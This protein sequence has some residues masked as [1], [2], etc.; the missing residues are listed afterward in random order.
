MQSTYHL[1]RLAN[2]TRLAS[3]EMPYMRSV[4]VGIWVGVGG[5]HE[6]EEQS[7]ISHFLEHLLFKGTK[8]RSAKKITES[9]EGLGG[10]LN[11]FTTEDH[12]CYYAK[13][14]APH[15][16]QLCDVLCDMYLE[17]VFAPAE[18]EREREVIREEILMYR[19]H[20][21]QHAQELLT[22]TMWPQHPL[23]RPLTGSVETISRFK[24]G[25][26]MKFQKQNYT[27]ATTIVTVAGPVYHERVVE[28]LKP[29]LSRLPRGRAPRYVRAQREKGPA[30]LS[31]Y[32]QETEQT[33]L[34]MGFHAFGRA[35]E[36]RFA[37][38]LLS[39]ILGEN[40]SSRLFQK[41]RERHGWCYNVQTSMVTLADT[42]AI[43]VYAGLDP[44][45]L[46]KAIRLIL[47]EL[48][49]ICEKAPGRAELRKAQD[50]T[51]GQTLMGLESTSNQLMWMGE[52]LLGY[53]KILDPSEVEQRVLAVTAEDIK[54]VACYCLNR[55]KLGIAI[56]GPAQDREK[57]RGWLAG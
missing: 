40:M 50:Y 20:P 14:A 29:V 44:G 9:V 46:E 27:G 4:S 11:A 49:N 55:V 48:Q 30:R 56:V 47:R 52:S 36:R 35:D 19:D 32:T 26:L 13:A 18:I 34:A 22:E 12:T 41:L 10:Y 8:R 42:G 31:L 51:I 38:K 15:L 57:V 23:G 43:H 25:D 54:R 53:G 21:A 39:V 16:P 3:V 6:P 24:R 45:N 2:G 1:T 33:H 17:S 5:R 28:L 37:L 7:G